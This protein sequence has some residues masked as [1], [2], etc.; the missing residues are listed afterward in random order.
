MSGT[1]KA[2]TIAVIY[3]STLVKQPVVSLSKNGGEFR[4][5]LTLTLT[6]RNTTEATY[7]IGN[8]APVSYVSG[9]TITIGANM[10][11]NES[12]DIT[13]FGK[14][15]E[16]DTTTKIYTHAIK[17]ADAAAAETLDNIFGGQSANDTRKRA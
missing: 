12:V 3:N 8:G 1:V 13:L 16:G 14:N 17:S 7:K 2:N 10:A 6:A 15:S 4:G 11:D 9:D 5:T